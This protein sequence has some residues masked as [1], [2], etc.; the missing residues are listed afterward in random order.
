MLEKTEKLTTENATSSYLE[1]EDT[2]PVDLTGTHEA[3][4]FH[5]ED[6]TSAKNTRY[7]LVG[8]EI[9]SG[10]GQGITVFGRVFRGRS[11]DQFLQALGLDPK[12]LGNRLS[13]DQVIGTK[14]RITLAAEEVEGITGRPETRWN[15]RAFSPF[16]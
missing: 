6:K 16:V 3:R 4:V 10:P 5:V 14:V 1:L 8:T 9:I 7:L 11:W 2:G 13:G 15:I 12:A